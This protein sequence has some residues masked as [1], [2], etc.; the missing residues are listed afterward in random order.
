[1]ICQSKI[2]CFL[3]FQQLDDFRVDNHFVQNLL[4]LSTPNFKNTMHQW[5]KKTDPAHCLFQINYLWKAF[6][7]KMC[8]LT[9]NGTC[10]CTTSAN[11]LYRERTELADRTAC[12]SFVLHEW[13]YHKKAFCSNVMVLFL[14]QYQ[15]TMASF[16]QLK[17]SVTRV[18]CI[19][20]II[21]IP[22]DALSEHYREHRFRVSADPL[23][24][25]RRRIA[26]WKEIKILVMRM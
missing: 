16:S 10:K 19:I 24:R 26:K 15:Y 12:E 25:W 23:E 2:N 9:P 17:Q 11:S 5:I 8:A 7:K 18:V 13:H 22:R 21:I 14:F 3:F 6:K 4:L 1:M 20:I